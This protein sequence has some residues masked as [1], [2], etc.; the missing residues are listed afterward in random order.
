MTSS[1][2]E[3]VKRVPGARWVPTEIDEAGTLVETAWVPYGA[4]FEIPLAF[5]CQGETPFA[6]RA[7]VAAIDGRPQCIEFTCEAT[8][9]S[10]GDLTPISPEALHNLPLGRLIRDQTLIASREID[11]VPRRF[12]RWES[13][14]EAE[15]A[16]GAVALQYRKRPASR[17]QAL[18][19]ERLAEVAEVYRQNISTGKPSLAV[20]K[21][22][23]Y[24]PTSARR[25]VREARLRGLLGAA[26][27]G[28]GGEIDPKETEVNSR[29]LVKTND[30]GIYKRG[31][32]YVVDLPRRRRGGNGSRRRRRSPRPASIRAEAA[33]TRARGDRVSREPF[34]DYARQW[35]ETC[36]GR[37]KN[38]LREKT[39]DDY[40]QRLEL[41]AIPL[42][43]GVRM[44]DLRAR[45]LDRVAETDRE[46]QGRAGARSRSARTRFGSG[47]PR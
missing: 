23:N 35:I 18:T 45:H 40:R 4:G 20:A 14:K 47:W 6:W 31:N 28:R 37:T 34:R 12:R 1:T 30:L 38:G 11:D 3:L 7:I 39:R 2:R 13:I 8:A 26:K 17:P 36:P 5:V 27:P 21:H 19:D 25:V 33:S 44:C 10:R 15:E 22:F 42:L 29:E 16:K 24:S 41:D 46:A 32:R 43:G 9:D